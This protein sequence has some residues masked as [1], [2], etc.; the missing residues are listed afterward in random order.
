MNVRMR[1]M[2]TLQV[3]LP[4]F[5]VA[6][7][8]HSLSLA[9]VAQNRAQKES[10][11]FKNVEETVSKLLSVPV[12]TG[13]DEKLLNEAGDGAA[14]AITRIVSE[15][16]MNSPDTGRRIL[17]ILHLAFEAPQSIIGRSNKAPTAALRLLNQLEHTDYGRQPNV[18]GNARF[19]IKHNTCTGRPLE[20]VTLPGEPVIDWGHTQ[21]VGNVLA[22][23]A[24]IKP[25]MTRSDLLRVFTTEGGLSTRTHRTYVLKP[26][27]TIKVD[28]EFSIS[29]NEAEDKITQISRPY[30]DYGHYD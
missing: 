20:P 3:V 14:L 28:V 9:A 25:G 7:L 4:F 29:G 5:L 23:I 6:V 1:S 16:E 27:P 17:L 13:S 18:I 22:W 12:Y 10:A 30:L 8:T 2:L 11:S 19:E 21:W 15:Q 24:T 26:C